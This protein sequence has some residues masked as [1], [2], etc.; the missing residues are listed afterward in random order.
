MSQV[1]AAAL[2]GFAGVARPWHL[3]TAQQAQVLGIDDPAVLSGWLE[4]AARHLP[5]ENVP[6]RLLARIPT[7]VRIY[8]ELHQIFRDPVQADGWIHLPNTASLFSGAPALQLLCVGRAQ[9]VYDYLRS[10]TG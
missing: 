3:T 4:D 8:G 5:V 7:L 9:E 6:L 2:R 1:A 10:Q